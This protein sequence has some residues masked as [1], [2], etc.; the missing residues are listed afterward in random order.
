MKN[1]IFTT[2]AILL[3]LMTAVALISGIAALSEGNVEHVHTFRVLSNPVSC[4]SAFAKIEVCSICGVKRETEYPAAGHIYEEISRVD[5][6][7]TSNGV[8][9]E[10]CARCRD[11]R[12]V[13]LLALGHNY[14]F[15]DS[16]SSFSSCTDGGEYVEVCSRCKHINRYL[17]APG[18]HDLTLREGENPTCI[19]AGHSAYYECKKCAYIEGREEIAPLGHDLVEIDESYGDE[20]FC[21][22][23]AHR[24][25]LR[26][27]Y[28]E[29][30][31]DHF[32]EHFWVVEPGYP[33]TC[34]DSGLSDMRYCANCNLII[35]EQVVL[36]AEH[37]IVF[38]DE[39]EAS[40]DSSGHSAYTTCEKCSYESG[41]E[42]VPMLQHHY[43]DHLI[44][45]NCGYFP[46][47]STIAGTTWVINAN[48]DTHDIPIQ[49]KGQTYSL[50][51]VVN[52]GYQEYSTLAIGMYLNESENSWYDKKGTIGVSDGTSTKYFENAS[53]TI[54]FGNGVDCENQNLIGWLLRNA[55]CRNPGGIVT[56]P[57]V[58]LTGTEWWIGEDALLSVHANLQMIY[59]VQIEL[60]LDSYSEIAIGARYDAD[61]TYIPASKVVSLDGWDVID[62]GNIFLRFTG[63]ED[64]CN[65]ELISW[66]LEN[67]EL[68]TG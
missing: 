22:F 31:R 27:G 6:T 63:G 38:H 9:E 37:T 8:V 65:P 20:Q 7:C 10:E 66:L 34:T 62:D 40:C 68:Q 59:D 47:I 2:L 19:E 56:Q 23:S 3:V 52:N 61:G 12:T 4:T 5:A 24:D 64:S 25:C 42:Y 29:L 51:F 48:F 53:F 54:S 45:E 11:K 17:T 49:I 36:P 67:A 1:K 44:C 26:C 18:A 14:E 46:Q 58:D 57:L 28:C 33:S 55:T 41:Y 21:G 32:C 43:D 39:K 16:K 50:S 13:S 30:G 15:D 60:D 35:E